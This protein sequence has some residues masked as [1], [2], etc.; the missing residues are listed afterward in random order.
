MIRRLTAL[1]L[2]A[3]T[4]LGGLRPSQADAQPPLT[5][6][7]STVNAG[8]GD[9]LDPHVDCNLATFTD[10]GG[11]IPR[12]RYFDFGAGTDAAVPAS[13]QNFLPDVSGS[14]I[15]FTNLTSLGS[16]IAVFDTANGSSFLVPGGNERSSPSIAGN[17]VAF[18]DRGFSPTQ[19]SPR[20][21]FTTSRPTS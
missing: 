15:A 13:G 20:S 12:V 4:V 7:T 8:P 18:E 9:Q 16:Q 6:S 1:T 17:L 10:E 21:S 19:A 2:I 5:G 3:L 11:G 14:R